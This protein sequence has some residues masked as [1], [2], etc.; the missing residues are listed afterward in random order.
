[1]SQIVYILFLVGGYVQVKMVEW[2][3][4]AIG[5]LTFALLISLGMNVMPDDTHFC[6]SLE[7]AV[8]CDRLSSTNKTC[9]PTPVVRLGSKFCVETWEEIM[10]EPVLK[11]GISLSNVKP[12]ENCYYEQIFW[13]ETISIYQN[14]TVCN[15]TFESKIEKETC[16]NVSEYIGSKEVELNKYVCKEKYIEYNDIKFDYVKENKGCKYNNTHIMCDDDS[17]GD[18]NGDGIC[19]S[20]ETCHTYTLTD[21]IQLDSIYN[22]DVRIK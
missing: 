20:G 4:Y 5:T 21:K 6:R 10:I 17:T 22:G 19:Q 7:L 14:I 1:M 13:N 12:I 9:Y 15:T 11:S 16:Y 18:G 3:N 2:S 8:Y